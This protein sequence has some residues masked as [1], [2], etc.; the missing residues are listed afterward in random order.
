MN[1]GWK[2]KILGAT[3]MVFGFGVFADALASEN[4]L[5]ALIGAACAFGGG[6]LFLTKTVKI[7]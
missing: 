6:Y 3:L 4:F 1:L 7:S 2:L 5:V